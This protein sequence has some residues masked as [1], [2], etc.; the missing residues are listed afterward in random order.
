MAIGGAEGIG[1]SYYGNKNFF[2]QFSMKIIDRNQTTMLSDL[3][4]QNFSSNVIFLVEFWIVPRY[5][6]FI[7]S[8]KSI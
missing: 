1:I 3:M 5:N 6:F 4:K 7:S 2:I 8:L